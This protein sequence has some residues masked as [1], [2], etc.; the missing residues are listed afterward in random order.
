METTD[1]K[2]SFTESEKAFAFF[3]VKFPVNVIDADLELLHRTSCELGGKNGRLCLHESESSKVHQMIVLEHS[4]Y[5]YS[6][7]YHEDDAECFMLMDGSLGLLTFSDDGKLDSAQLLVKHEFCKVGRGVV[8]AVFPAS[9]YCIYYES[10]GGPFIP[11]QSSLIP[12]WAP[13][14][15]DEVARYKNN[16][17][18]VLEITK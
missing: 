12:N 11:S 10:K 4:R 3:P 18:R 5:F 13:K 15:E 14:T 9:N 1:E 8:H 17:S 6:P 16:V 2:W 7:H